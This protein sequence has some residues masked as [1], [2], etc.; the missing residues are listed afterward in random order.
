MKH[1]GCLH[2]ELLLQNVII[3]T[4]SEFLL[5]SNLLWQFGTEKFAMEKSLEHI[6]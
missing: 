6:F 2:I 5:H 3:S 1:I 4:H